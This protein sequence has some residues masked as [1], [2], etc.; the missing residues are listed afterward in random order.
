MRVHVCLWRGGV[1]VGVKERV[2][3][4]PANACQTKQL[5]AAARLGLQRGDQLEVFRDARG[6]HGDDAHLA[7]RCMCIVCRGGACVV[8]GERAGVGASAQPDARP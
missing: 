8:L 3:A 4:P 2:M 1:E 6:G 7:G 5:A